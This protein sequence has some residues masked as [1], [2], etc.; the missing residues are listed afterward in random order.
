MPT[1]CVCDLVL[2]SNIVFPE[3]PPARGKKPACVLKVLKAQAPP[4]AAERVEWFHRW[5]LPDGDP[6]LLF[7][8]HRR[9]HLLRF[10]RFGDFL[11]SRNGAQVRCRPR[12]AI[13]LD[14]VRHL[15]LDQVFPLLLS[16]RG[17]LV[18]HASAV[19]VPGG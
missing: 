15:F 4:R 17:R 8:R 18:L 13:P 5:H 16:K 11:V 3:L 14:T 9:G 2:Q 7:G 6:W 12:K 19:L 10:P 1:Y